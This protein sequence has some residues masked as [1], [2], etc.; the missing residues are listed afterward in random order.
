MPQNTALVIT[1][2]SGPNAAMKAF[3][4]GCRK[5]GIEFI[6]VGDTKS[7]KH[8]ELEGCRFVGIE[9]QRALPFKIARNLPEKHY[10]R[11][12]LGYLLSKSKD[13]II[14]T[15]DDNFPLENFWNKTPDQEDARIINRKDWVN[16]Y[17]YFSEENIWPRGFPLEVLSISPVGDDDISSARANPADVTIMQGLADDNPDVDAVYRMAMKLPVRFERKSPLILGTGAWCPFNSQNTTWK[18]EAFPLLYL[19]SY[20]SFRMTDIWRSFIAQRIAWTCGWKIL[21]HAADVRQ[22]RNEHNL[23]QDF[24]DEIPGYLNNMRIC[25][26]L[27]ELNLLYGVQNICENLLR[28]YRLMTENNWIGKKE[29]ELVDAWCGEFQR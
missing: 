29:M 27:V 10:A 8:F 1:S 16:A 5:N 25:R 23:L 13:V 24:T 4:T 20:C 21:F 2:I 28:C 18:K 14:E 15:D 19:P 3:A 17:R 26:E 9:E 11:K 6:V 7:P 12:N 22:E